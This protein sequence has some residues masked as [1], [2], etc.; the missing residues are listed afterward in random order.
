MPVLSCVPHG[1]FVILGHVLLSL[2]VPSP[3]LPDYCLSSSCP[4]L[5]YS[6]S[7]VSSCLQSS[8]SGRCLMSPVP[9]V[10]QS[11]SRSRCFSFIHC[12]IPPRGFC[13]VFVCF[14][15]K[16][17]CSPALESSHPF[18]LAHSMT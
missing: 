14:I 9:C 7:Y 3:S 16:V 11:K 12:A 17:S 6:L 4:L 1:C 18:F 2:S 10:P 8:W 5:I 13:F 15:I